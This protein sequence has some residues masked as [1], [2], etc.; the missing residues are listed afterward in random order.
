MRREYPLNYLESIASE[1]NELGSIRRN[2]LFTSGFE[3]TNYL[4]ETDGGSF[5]IKI[6]EGTDIT[7]EIAHFEA[8]VMDTCYRAGVNTPRVLSTGS[9]SLVSFL[10]GKMAVVME[11]VTGENMDKGQL[12]DD[13]AYQIGVETGAMD[14]AL[15]AFADGSKT[16]QGYEWDAK[17]F[18]IHEP[19]MQYLS[20]DFDTKIFEDIFK[21]FR[22]IQPVFIAQPT[23]LIHNDIALQNIIVKDGALAAII[24]FSDIAF[25]PYIQNLAVP[26][27]QMFFSYN[28]NP[29]QAKLFLG[30][31]R[32]RRSVSRDELSLLYD[33]TCARFACGIIGFNYWNE[34][35]FG[36]DEERVETVQD[37]YGFLKKF[38]AFG[39]DA[40]FEQVLI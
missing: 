21:K 32:T 33:L 14:A 1:Y 30:G 5:V 19:R 18:L 35:V 24:D 10:D 9:G 3:N 7:A 16:R 37:F 4:I 2:L 17:N 25:S 39:P 26:M 36:R 38:I 27:C 12:T 34:V 20:A 6:F 11:Y 28:W 8:T 15:S 31:Y 13:I 29:A 22:R 40:F 23:G